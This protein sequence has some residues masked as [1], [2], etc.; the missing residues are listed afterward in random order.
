MTTFSRK[1]LLFVF[2]CALSAAGYAQETSTA[3]SPAVVN[4]QLAA[5]NQ[6][7]LQGK[8]E[9]GSVSIAAQSQQGVQSR[10]DISKPAVGN[11]GVAGSANNQT[12]TNSQLTTTSNATTAANTTPVQTP[13]T[14]SNTQQAQ[15]TSAQLSHSVN[16]SQTT[17]GAN[18]SLNKVAEVTKNASAD[19]AGS[20]KTQ[21]D[22]A[23]SIASNVSAHTQ[24]TLASATDNLRDAQAST[25]AAVSEAVNSNLNNTVSLATNAVISQEVSNQ[26][27]TVV[28]QEIGKAVQSSIDS[29]VKNSV[30]Q[31]LGLGL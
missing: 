14:A 26:V 4:S 22:F 6:S 15:T 13:G 19:V 23:Q 17:Q 10:I 12:N 31:N 25:T 8:A 27:N 11:S 29:T 21:A 7:T 1:S 5:Q 9:P 30:T 18:A 16:V 20:I 3:A 2:T 24:S 28:S